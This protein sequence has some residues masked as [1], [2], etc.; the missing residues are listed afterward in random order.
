MSGRGAWFRQLSLGAVLSIMVWATMGADGGGC[1]GGF[2]SGGG[3]GNWEY[4]DASA[5]EPVP[6]AKGAADSEQSG[7]RQDRGADPGKGQVETVA[8]PET[9]VTVWTYSMKYGEL[10]LS[11][12][13]MSL[14]ANVPKPGPDLGFEAPGLVMGLQPLMAG[15]SQYLP[16]LQDCLRVNFAPDGAHAY[17]LGG[18]ASTL[19][20]VDLATYQVVGKHTFPGLYSVL[21]VTL[22]GRFVVLSNLPTTAEKVYAFDPYALS[23]APESGLKLPA[24]SSLCEVAVYDLEE[25]LGWTLELPHRLRDFDFDPESGEMLF[26]Y[27]L[28]KGGVDAVTQSFLLFYNASSGQFTAKLQFENCSDE[29]VVSSALGL[30][31]QSPTAC[32]RPLG[33]D[34]ANP[35][36]DQESAWG[37]TAPFSD[38]ISVVDLKKR[39][40]VTNLPGFGPVALTDDGLTAAGFT[41]Q[42]VMAEEWDYHGQNDLVG[43][44][45]VDLE[46]LEWEIIDVGT[47]VPAYTF[48]PDGK[49]LYLYSD[50][51]LSNSQLGRM[52]VLT[53]KLEWLDG[54]SVDLEAFVWSPS[55]DQLFTVSDGTLYQVRADSTVVHELALPVPADR[56]NIRPQGDY[57][58]VAPTDSAVYYAFEIPYDGSEMVVVETYDMELPGLAL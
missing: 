56:I 54:P 51:P 11:P 30:A 2:S 41:L 7:G 39:Q 26:S 53:R 28:R 20:V 40:F 47:E 44:I 33:Y 27:A 21:D 46:T 9:G 18:D 29:V 58:L 52:D 6:H 24:G 19:F 14:M 34:P 13:G 25:A 50:N 10:I 37:G 22:D 23:C 55:G 49:F 42:A 4:A 36:N 17:V 1:G 32:T 31:L 43:I 16:Q 15:A 35:V 57:I 38:P 8:D 48:S 12:D 45:L 3:S 5:G